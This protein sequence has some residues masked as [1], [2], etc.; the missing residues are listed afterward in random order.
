[1][2]CHTWIYEISCATTEFVNG[3]KE[4]IISGRHEKEAEEEGKGKMIL[5]PCRDFNNFKNYR[6]VEPLR[7]HLFRRNFK[8]GYVKWICRSCL[9]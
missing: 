4:F 5:C 2:D 6:S 8:E 9:H 3:V 7:D 1:M